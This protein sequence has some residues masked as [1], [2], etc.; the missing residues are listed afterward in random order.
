VLALEDHSIVNT[1][2]VKT[3]NYLSTNILIKEKSGKKSYFK[4]KNGKKV[5]LNRFLLPKI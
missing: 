5:P 3:H 1:D 2:N 4:T